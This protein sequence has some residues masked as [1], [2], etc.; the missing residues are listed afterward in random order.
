M[1]I[2]LLPAVDSQ[3]DTAKVV[4]TVAGGLGGA[5]LIA[6][7]TALRKLCAFCKRRERETEKQRAFEIAAATTEALSQARAGIEAAATEAANR[8]TFRLMSDLEERYR[9]QVLPVEVRSATRP[10]A[11]RPV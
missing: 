10:R 8:H 6:L 4:L 5:G 9:S 2:A 7:C 3:I 11:E 1:S